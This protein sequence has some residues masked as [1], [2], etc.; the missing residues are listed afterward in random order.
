MATIHCFNETRI[1]SDQKLREKLTEL[2][3]NAGIRRITH[4]TFDELLGT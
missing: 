4:T 1:L 2:C 3:I